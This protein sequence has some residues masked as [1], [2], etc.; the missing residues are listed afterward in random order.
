MTHDP[1]SYLI[2]LIPGGIQIPFDHITLESLASDADFNIGI[3]L[4]LHQPHH[5]VLGNQTL[6]PYQVDP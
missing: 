5:F 2:H 4:P 1:V 6:R 3:T